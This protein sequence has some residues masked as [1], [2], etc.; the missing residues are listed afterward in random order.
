MEQD[1]DSFNPESLNHIVKDVQNVDFAGKKRR[2]NIVTYG[3]KREIN[4]NSKLLFIGNLKLEVT[5]KELRDA[6]EEFGQIET[7]KMNEKPL[8]GLKS[9]SIKFKS[10]QVSQQ[11]VICFS[12]SQATMRFPRVL[13]LFDKRILIVNLIPKSEL[14]A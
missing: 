5:E 10:S 7:I 2:P 14:Q 13:S 9:A 6:F 1:I 4:K 3:P 12:K 11:I 8:K